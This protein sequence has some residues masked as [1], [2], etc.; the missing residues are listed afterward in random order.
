MS[1]VLPNWIWLP[2]TGTY[3]APKVDLAALKPD[4][5]V[6][7]PDL[8]DQGCCHLPLS[9][10]FL[11]YLQKTITHGALEMDITAMHGG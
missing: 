6:P 4:L 9:Q 11:A 3:G 8:D 5:V 7:L 2:A 1:M 10:V